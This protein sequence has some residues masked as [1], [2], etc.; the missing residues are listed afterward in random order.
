MT[1]WFGMAQDICYGT[2]VAVPKA[3]KTITMK[4]KRNTGLR[5]EISLPAWI[6]MDALVEARSEFQR[7]QEGRKDHLGY[8]ARTEATSWL[9]AN[10]SAWATKLGDFDKLMVSYALCLE[11]KAV[12][13]EERCW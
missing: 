11:K 5:T 12:K 3:M 6:T 13:F 2:R 9:D 4:A 10:R 7:H 1:D 8:C